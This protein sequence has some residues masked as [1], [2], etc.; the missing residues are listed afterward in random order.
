MNND[1]EKQIQQM[2]KLADD[3]EK[4]MAQ[5]SSSDNLSWLL[6]TVLAQL[7]VFS[8]LFTCYKIVN[9]LYATPP[10]WV[11]VLTFF[12]VIAISVCLKVTKS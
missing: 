1:H 4:K 3:E 5:K 9:G 7:V 12:A 6:K 8:A 10:N 11:L 2:I